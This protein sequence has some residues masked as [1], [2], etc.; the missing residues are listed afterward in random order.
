[1]LLLDILGEFLGVGDPDLDG[2]DLLIGTGGG[3]LLSSSS[4]LLSSSSSLSISSVL[5]LS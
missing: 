5:Y 3:P 2:D 1:M 4:S